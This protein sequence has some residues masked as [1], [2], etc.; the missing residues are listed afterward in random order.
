MRERGKEGEGV[1]EGETG[2]SETGR[3]RK[4]GGRE[5]M[6]KRARERKTERNMI[7]GEKKEVQPGEREGERKTVLH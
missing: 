3:E 4:G 6:G 7:E 2:W 1:K 5:N